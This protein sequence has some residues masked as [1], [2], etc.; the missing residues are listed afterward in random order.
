MA[1]MAP[2]TPWLLC[3]STLPQP[4]FPSHWLPTPPPRAKAGAAATCPMSELESSAP[5]ELPLAPGWIWLARSPVV[6]IQPG[7][8]GEF[9]AP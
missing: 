4:Y 2:V 9:D 6:P 8:E 7:A 1:H 3:P 5:P